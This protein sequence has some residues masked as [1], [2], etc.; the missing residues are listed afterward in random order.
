MPPFVERPTENEQHLFCHSVPPRRRHSSSN[1]SRSLPRLHQHQSQHCHPSQF[2]QYTHFSPHPS[3]QSVEDSDFNQATTIGSTSCRR[4]QSPVSTLNVSHSSGR[5]VHSCP[6][7]NFSLGQRSNM[8]SVLDTS[9][10]SESPDTTEPLRARSSK[11]SRPDDFPSLHDGP[12]Q[13]QSATTDFR[14]GYGIHPY[15]VRVTDFHTFPQSTQDN[16]PSPPSVSVARAT[17]KEHTMFETHEDEPF[18]QNL[19]EPESPTHMSSPTRWPL[20]TPPRSPTAV[21]LYGQSPT[22]PPSVSNSFSSESSSL[23]L[24]SP[25]EASSPSLTSHS[26]SL[27]HGA[28]TNIG[29]GEGDCQSYS[30]DGYCTANGIDPNDSQHGQP[31]SEEDELGSAPFRMEPNDDGGVHDDNAEH[32]DGDDTDDDEYRPATPLNYFIHNGWKYDGDVYELR[33]PQERSIASRPERVLEH[34]PAP[35]PHRQTFNRVYSEGTYN[36]RP[37]SLRHTSIPPSPENPEMCLD[38]IK[39]DID[40]IQGGGAAPFN[41]F[42]GISMP[43]V[44]ELPTN[45]VAHTQPEPPVVKPAS[46]VP[47]MELRDGYGRIAE[48]DLTGSDEKAGDIFSDK[49][50]GFTKRMNSGGDALCDT[51]NEELS[52]A[53]IEVTSGDVLIDENGVPVAPLSSGEYFGRGRRLRRGALYRSARRL[54]A[55]SCGTFEG[56]GEAR[57][58][59]KSSRPSGSGRQR[60]TSLWKLLTR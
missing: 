57:L 33:P 58:S 5:D 60:R 26:P 16:L 34:K 47:T 23:S 39:A 44:A 10:I 18:S 36:T 29:N 24:G 12:V 42:I 1:V 53:T 56:E 11:I 13:P 31:R 50:A 17:S 21:P 9:G 30:D 43:N 27:L 35:L 25:S 4:D 14:E 20:V 41:E 37:S 49:R 59:E 38:Y 2:T 40:N 32:E 15:D 55:G 8:R 28:S 54:A 52:V 46:S 19:A 3:S 7:D 6:P 45:T 22:H 48:F 51:E